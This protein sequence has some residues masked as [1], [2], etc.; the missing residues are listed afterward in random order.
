MSL[1]GSAWLGRSLEMLPVNIS[2]RIASVGRRKGKLFSQAKPS[3]FTIRQKEKI[4]LECKCLRPQNAHPVISFHNSR[5]GVA[6]F[7]P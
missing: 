7:D 4:R 2:P 1:V 3:C 5:P 6:D